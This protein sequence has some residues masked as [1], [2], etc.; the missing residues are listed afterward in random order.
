MNV[1]N[2]FFGFITKY[3]ILALHDTNYVTPINDVVR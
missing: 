3:E 1:N 2:A